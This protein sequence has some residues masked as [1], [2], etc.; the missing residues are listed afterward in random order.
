MNNDQK[1]PQWI[2]LPLGDGAT[3]IGISGCTISVIGDVLGVTPDVVNSILKTVGGFSGALV[4]WA[5]LAIAFPGITVNRVWTYNN[6][7]VLNQLAANNQVIVEVPAAPIGG[8]G[9]HWVQYI[10]N[11]QLKDPWTGTIRPTTDF[12]NPTGYAVFS[13]K[14]QAAEN[15]APST[16]AVNSEGLNTYGLDP[17]NESSNQIVF[18]TWHDVSQGL[19]V[20]VAQYNALN[21]STETLREN[22]DKLKGK[23][24]TLSTELTTV[25]G[26]LETLKKSDYDYGVE[27]KEAKDLADTYTKYMNDFANELQLADNNQTEQQVHDEIIKE[28]IQLR[29]NQ[30]TT[31]GEVAPDKT[32]TTWENGLKNIVDWMLSHGLNEWLKEQGVQL[33]NFDGKP[34]EDVS[35]RIIAYLDDRFHQIDILKAAING[36]KIQAGKSKN[37]FTQLLSK[38][39]VTT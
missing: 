32:L 24:D 36:M 18:Q 35:E 38:F 16:S 39:F 37:F 25:N 11:H 14:Y 23:Y 21:N 5:K 34:E 10:G 19:Y 6:D 13:G 4:I 28:I 2:N 33:V 29:A 27:A 20:P 8:T 1:D 9:S 7:D 26:T 30:K 17:T 15:P 22:F 12:P 3:T 31:E